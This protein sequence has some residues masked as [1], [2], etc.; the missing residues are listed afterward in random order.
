MHKFLI[1]FLLCQSL[2]FASDLTLYS[3]RAQDKIRPVLDSFTAET[4]IKINVVEGT[5]EKLL[6]KLI[7]EDQATTADLFLTKDLVY[8]NEAVQK[9]IF[10]SMPNILTNID[11]RLIEKN[12]KWV[13]LSYRARPIMINPNKVKTSEITSYADLA[14]PEFKGRLCL[15]ESYKTYNQ[16]LIASLV[17]RHGLK[18]TNH[19]LT[20][21]K[22]NLAIPFLESDTKVLEAINQGLCDV[23]ITNTYYLVYLLEKNPTLITRPHFIENTHI[24]GGG[25]GIVRHSKNITNAMKL[26]E[27]L[28]TVKAQEKFAMAHAEYPAN[29]QAKIHPTLMQWGEFSHEPFHQDELGVLSNL[30]IDLARRAGH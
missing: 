5:H 30:S 19:I 17:A 11:A 20:A 8:L 23:G 29:P 2:S 4:G 24:N 9:N 27:Y 12:Q 10:I 14:R 28:L 1:S 3:V 18:E 16:A 22:E 15:R 7:N 26:V 25:I 21:L 13:T 6:E